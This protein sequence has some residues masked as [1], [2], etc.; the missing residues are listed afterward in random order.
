MK[1]NDELLYTEYYLCKPYLS[2]PVMMSIIFVSHTLVSQWW[3]LLMM[4]IRTSSEYFDSQSAGSIEGSSTSYQAHSTV[5]TWYKEP[6][7]LIQTKCK[8]TCV[9]ILPHH[10]LLSWHGTKYLVTS[11]KPSA[12][13]LRHFVQSLAKLRDLVT[14]MMKIFFFFIIQIFFQS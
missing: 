14:W 8:V 13:W 1:F 2:Q 12:R 7:N 3:C 11:Y 4:L 10:T 5:M 9:L 6:G